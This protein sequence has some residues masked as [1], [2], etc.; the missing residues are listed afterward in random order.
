MGMSYPA[1]IRGHENIPREA[2]KYKFSKHHNCWVRTWF[3]IEKDDDGVSYFRQRN[4][5][6]KDR[7]T[8]WDKWQSKPQQGD[9]KWEK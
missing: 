7:N 2:V 3:T 4:A 1:P 6:S 5:F 8:P 9:I